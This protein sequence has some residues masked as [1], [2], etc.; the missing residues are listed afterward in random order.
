MILFCWEEWIRW[1]HLGCQH[2][3]SCS[4][5]VN[6][7]N[8]KLLERQIG[9]CKL[10]ETAKC[11]SQW[12]SWVGCL[13]LFAEHNWGYSN[14]KNVCT[15]CHPQACMCTTANTRLCRFD[16]LI[17][18]TLFWIL[19]D[20]TK[21][22]LLHRQSSR[23]WL[24]SLLFLFGVLQ[25]IIR[26]LPDNALGTVDDLTLNTPV[27]KCLH[28]LPQIRSSYIYAVAKLGAICCYLLT[29]YLHIYRS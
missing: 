21:A 23:E 7:L 27:N 19:S 25:T 17:L 15:L 10:C 4:F 28:Q 22:L 13:L 16:I 9:G 6:A 8:V 18:F 14:S 5:I 26:E 11:V 1:G 12:I 29:D 3:Q 24:S 2:I 20:A